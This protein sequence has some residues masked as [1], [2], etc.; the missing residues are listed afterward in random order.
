MQMAIKAIVTTG[1]RLVGLSSFIGSTG[2]SYR[3]GV[4]RVALV[5]HHG[6]TRARELAVQAIEWLEAEGHQVK[7]PKADA[8]TCGLEAWAAD[9]DELGSSTDLAVSLGGDGTMLRTV[10]LVAPSGAPVLGVNVGRLGYLTEVGPEDLESALERLVTGRHTVEERIVLEVQVSGATP[11]RRTALN[12]AVLEKPHSG[13]T[14][15]LAVEID[16]SFFTTYVA[17]GLIVATPTGS[18]AYNLSVRGPILSPLVKGLVLTPVA[19][20]MLFDRSL[21]LPDTGSIRIEVRDPSSAALVI[22][23]QSALV[24]APGDAIECR[25]GAHPA[26]LVTFAERDFHSRLKAKFGL[27]DR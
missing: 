7:V 17:D 25:V 19:P 13:H 9:D 16:G 12:E 4:S 27:S 2:R 6:R 26:R 20:H 22:D 3:W 21:V 23:G 5:V 24:L 15:S 14:V 11:L 18:T 10:D 8:M 1:A